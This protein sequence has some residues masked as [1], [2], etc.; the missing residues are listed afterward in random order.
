MQQGP[1]MVGFS[2]AHGVG[3][4]LL[5]APLALVLWLAVALLTMAMSFWRRRTLS[6]QFWSSLAIAV[7]MLGFLALPPVFWQWLFIQSF[8][9]S[10]HAK[11]L[12]TYAAANGQVR[13]VRGY[14]AQGVPLEST[15]YQGST[16]AFTAAAGGSVPVIEVLASKGANLNALNSYGDSPLEAAIE[17]QHNFVVAFLKAHG[18]MQIHGTPEQREA[19]SQS[20]V[21]KQI[22]SMHTQ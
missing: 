9:K 13:T 18:A 2:L 11:D 5:L 12:M 1:Q 21:R 16:A 3:A 10:A 19:A 14:L 15:D 7:A 20:I 6:K 8:A 4:V 17:N 22:K